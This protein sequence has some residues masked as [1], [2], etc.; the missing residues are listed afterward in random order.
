GTPC[1]S[2]PAVRVGGRL[3]ASPTIIREKKIP[4]DRAEPELKNVPRMPAA[5]PRCPAGTAPMTAEV[6]G[7]EKR[8][9]PIPLIATRT[10][11]SQYGKSTGSTTSPTKLAATTSAPPTANGRA[12][13]WSDSQPD[14]GP[15]SRQPTGS[16]S[17]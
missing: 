9:E 11:K 12:P 15:A 14:T 4:I 16:G 3:A 6:L 10:A 7:E 13:K 1:C 17:R 5:A 8:P 2:R